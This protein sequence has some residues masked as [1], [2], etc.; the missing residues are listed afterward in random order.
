MMMWS[1]SEAD[2]N[3]LRTDRPGRA[4]PAAAD[5]DNLTCGKGLS[6]HDGPLQ[7]RAEETAQTTTRPP[8]ASHA[9]ARRGDAAAVLRARAGPTV[10]TGIR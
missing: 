6:E 2:K 5:S 8:P 1:F 9:S 10:G 3:M 7:A 4:G